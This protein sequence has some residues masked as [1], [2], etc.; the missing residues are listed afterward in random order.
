[1]IQQRIA[2][3]GTGAMGSRLALRLLAAG[4]NVT[5]FNRTPAN[6]QTLVEAGACF[7]ATPAQ[8][9]VY[10][11]CVISMLTDDQASRE[12]WLHP[13]H[14]ALVQMNPA[15]VV[16]EC[17]TVTPVWIDELAA[18]CAIRGVSLL[19]APVLGSRPQADAGALILLVG[20]NPDTLARV[21][22][23]L[24][25]V[26]RAVHYVGEQGAGAR[27]KLAV[28]ALFSVQVAA[29]AETLTWLTCSGMELA[30]CVAILNTLPTTSPALQGIG[31]LM[32]AGNFAPL[33]PIALVEKD[34]RYAQ[35][36]A[37]A[38]G[39]HVPLT[40]LTQQLYAAALEERLAEKNIAAILLAYQL[41]S[42]NL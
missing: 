37:R 42:G 22:L 30:E 36:T 26:S 10:A 39:A 33:F 41:N 3:L 28:N 29:W 4:Y 2:V 1:M 18:Q 27:L 16:L 15:S 23:L 31:Q 13:D 24:Q 12:V 17:S 11:D 7:A 40:A 19:D 14:G 20:G 25:H 9:V 5:V 8:A 34:L 6:A 35:Q 32:A 38:M 21:R